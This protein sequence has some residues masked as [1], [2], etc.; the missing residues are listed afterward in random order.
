MVHSE[1]VSIS[2]RSVLSAHWTPVI[3]KRTRSTLHIGVYS[4]DI[5]QHRC[6]PL[7][8]NKACWIFPL[9]SLLCECSPNYGTLCSLVAIRHLYT[10][11][12]CWLLP[13][14]NLLRLWCPSIRTIIFKNLPTIRRLIADMKYV[15]HRHLFLWS[16]LNIK[17]RPPCANIACQLLPCRWSPNIS[18]NIRPM[19]SV[20]WMVTRRQLMA[21]M[22]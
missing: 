7:E 16:M 4:S 3:W 14:H 8:T 20:H 19:S 10:N 22:K 21:R 17:R 12:T 5:C 13:L 9:H 2:I 15:T 18:K 11:I 6:S 1:R